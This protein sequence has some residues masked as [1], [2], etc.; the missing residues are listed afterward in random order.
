M[1][2]VCYSDEI[3]ILMEDRRKTLCWPTLKESI[4][5]YTMSRILQTIQKI[6]RLHTIC[7]LFI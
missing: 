4:T 7:V 1:F 3:Q 6:I 2:S 5:F